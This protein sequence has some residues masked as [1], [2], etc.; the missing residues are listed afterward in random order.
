M[1]SRDASTNKTLACEE[2]T[3]LIRHDSQS[4]ASTSPFYQ[5]RWRRYPWQFSVFLMALFLVFI[6]AGSNGATIPLR[7]LYESRVCARHYLI[8]DPSAILPDGS[9]PE[10]LCKI[11]AV[12]DELVMITSLQTFWDCIPS[13]LLTVP[14]GMMVSHARIVHNPH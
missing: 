14:Y 12:Q 2:T 9:V 6:E 3:P 10:R 13:I 7:R 8:H 4:Q 11:D 1:A 5:W